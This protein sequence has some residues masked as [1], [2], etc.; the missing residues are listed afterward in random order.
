[1]TDLRNTRKINPR[2]IN[3]VVMIGAGGKSNSFSNCDPDDD[4]WAYALDLAMQGV[5][6]SRSGTTL[7]LDYTQPVQW[8]NA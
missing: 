6:P 8:G 4:C 3:T 1:M 2:S 7:V 5:Q